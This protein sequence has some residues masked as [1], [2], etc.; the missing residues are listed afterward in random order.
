MEHALEKQE[1][2]VIFLLENVLHRPNLR[3]LDTDVGL[4]LK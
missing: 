1:I 3:E 4:I 2:Q